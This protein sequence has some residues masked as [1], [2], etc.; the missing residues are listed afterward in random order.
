MP[1]DLPRDQ[2]ASALGSDADH[3]VM[4]RGYSLAF[5][6]V[7]G[8]VR[9]VQ[10]RLS[11]TGFNA[12]HAQD[13]LAFAKLLDEFAAIVDR[14]LRERWAGIALRAAFDGE[15]ELIERLYEA[16]PLERCDKVDPASTSGRLVKEGE[17]VDARE[18]LVRASARLV[19]NWGVFARTP[20]LDDGAFAH[21]ARLRALVTG[22]NP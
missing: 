19:E 6:G 9:L 15:G 11:K 1:S 13:D 2:L 17:I 5:V 3:V 12:D 14:L 20:P 7:H 21:E 18:L 22:A 4:E 8:Q 10:F 16:G